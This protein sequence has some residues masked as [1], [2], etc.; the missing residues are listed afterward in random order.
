[1]PLTPKFGNIVS[2]GK[3]IYRKSVG[4]LLLLVP[5]MEALALP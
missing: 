4:V 1:M 3:C 2:N 5:R